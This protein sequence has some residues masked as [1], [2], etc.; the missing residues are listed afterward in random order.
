MAEGGEAASRASPTRLQIWI[1][2]GSMVVASAI[3]AGSS[4]AGRAAAGNVPPMALSFWRWSI[5]FLVLA[6]IAWRPLWRGR[7]IIAR[8]IPRY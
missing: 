6:A 1:A 2:V 3:F 4:V 7:A 8:N 5:A